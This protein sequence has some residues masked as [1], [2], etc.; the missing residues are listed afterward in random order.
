MSV[1]E[2]FSFKIFKSAATHLD[3]YRLGT[4]SSIQRFVQF[5]TNEYNLKRQPTGDHSEACSLW[6]KGRKATPS[7]SII[8][9]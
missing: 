2:R 1:A 7:V 4:Y 5:I 8:K 9:T 3:T 6:N